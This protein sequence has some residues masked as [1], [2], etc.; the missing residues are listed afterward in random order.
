MFEGA[1][2]AIISDAVFPKPAQG[3]LK[4]CSELSRIFQFFYALAEKIQNSIR[5]GFVEFAQLLQRC[6]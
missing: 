3:A 4:S 2:Q 5:Y 6:W 1:D